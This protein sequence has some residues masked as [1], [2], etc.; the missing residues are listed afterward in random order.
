MLVVL[1]LENLS[2]DPQE[3]FFADG[4]TEEMI[5]QLGRLD[6]QRLGVIART[7]SMQYKGTHEGTEQIARDL[8]VQY[9]LEGSVR[10]YGNNVRVTVQLIQSSDQTHIWAEDYD[11]QLSDVL[12]LQSEVACAVAGKI[13]LELSQETEERLAATPRVNPDAHEAYLEG[14]QAWNLRTPEGIERSIADFNAAIGIDSN[15]ALAYVALANAY[16]LAP[17][18]GIAKPVEAFPK[19]EAAATQALSLDGQLGEAYTALAFSKAHFDYDWPAAEREYQKGIDLDPNSA[20]AHLFYSNSYLSPLGRHEEAISEMK[21]AIELDPLS[22]PV[23]SFLGRTYV[24]ARRYNEARVQFLHCIEITPGFVLN[25]ERLSHLD[26]QLGDYENAIAE[27]TKARQFSG[28]QPAKV[29][30][31][32][33]ALRQAFESGGAHAFWLKL[34]ERADE[35]ENPPEAYTGAFGRAIIHAELG[36]KTEAIDWLE[37]SYAA[38]DLAMTELAITP[39]FDGLR[40]DPRF[41]TLVNRT[42]LGR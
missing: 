20:N 9:L 30:A 31:G 19:A 4:M 33:R 7:S 13:R 28:E 11:R 25:Y 10:R 26:A 32:E 39:E 41:Q 15:Y 37:R 38:R 5:T 21:R 24:W 23:Q 36:E 17:V 1:P 35:K 40:Q 8:G 42:G 18:F 22:P 12:E 6:P 3:E 29:V 34:L 16:N 27:D 14:L 2:G